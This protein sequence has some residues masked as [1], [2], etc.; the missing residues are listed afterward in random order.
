M[1]SATDF[2]RNGRMDWGDVNILGESWLTTDYRRHH[3]DASVAGGDGIVVPPTGLYA[4]NEVVTLT[5]K[6]D[7][8]W[9]I[10][11]WAGT[12]D[13]TSTDSTNTVTM[14]SNRIVTVE[15]EPI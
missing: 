14:T 7:A 13:D 4:Y 11:A 6:P 15:F 5:A 8:G 3:L 12:D 1:S 2:D 9:R 10:K